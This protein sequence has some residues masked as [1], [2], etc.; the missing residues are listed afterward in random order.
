MVTVKLWLSLL[1]L[2]FVIVKSQLFHKCRDIKTMPDF[3][4]SR[5]QGVWYDVAH[6]ENLSTW[7]EWDGDCVMAEY[8][9]ISEGIFHYR[10]SMSRRGRYS[11]ISGNGYIPDLSRPGEIT[12]KYGIV[13]AP[14]NVLETDYENW[15]LVY[16]CF[17]H[18][19][20]RFESPWILARRNEIDSNLRDY[21]INKYRRYGVD[22]F[23]FVYTKH[24]NCTYKP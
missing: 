7:F 4:M 21:L 23:K 2:L 19:C 6:L 14:Y 11:E 18:G 22:T 24:E 8:N 12:I 3:D 9:Y 13:S 16:S 20:F 10:N 5:Y 17:Y 1:S 15:A